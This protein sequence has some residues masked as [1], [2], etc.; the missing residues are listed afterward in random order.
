M[1]IAKCYELFTLL[2][3]GFSS[4][5]CESK[6]IMVFACCVVKFM[7][8]VVGISPSGISD[9]LLEGLKKNF[10]LVRYVL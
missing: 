9:Q 8:S 1:I 2:H 4:H 7:A 3:Y 10:T 6:Y 5:L